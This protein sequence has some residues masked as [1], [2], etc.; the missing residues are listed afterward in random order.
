MDN[1]LKMPETVWNINVIK[2]IVSNFLVSSALYMFYPGT[3]YV[4]VRTGG[5]YAFEE[6]LSGILF[7]IGAIVVAPFCNYCLDTYRRKTVVLW[8]LLC[9]AGCMALFFI[10]MSSASFLVLRTVQ[11][12]ACGVFQIALGS[13]LLLDLSLSKNR[14]RAAHIYYWI[15]RLSLAMGPLMAAVIVKYAEVSHLVAIPLAMSLIAFFLLQSLQVPFRAPLEPSLC[16]LDRFWLS[17]GSR[18]FIPLFGVTFTVGLFLGRNWHFE[19]YV[20]LLVGFLLSLGV[21]SSCFKQRYNEEVLCGLVALFTAFALL[22]LVPFISVWVTGI[23]LGA[24]L[25]LF[26]S[27]YLLAYIRVCEHC[28]RGT[29]Q[30]SYWL[31]WETGLA[32]GG[33]LGVTMYSISSCIVSA[34]ALVIIILVFFIHLFYIRNWYESHKRK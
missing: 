32:L 3:S 30:T 7:V 18:L 15:I 29:A 19:L 34:L 22:Q 12:A 25:G 23:L 6:S 2:I 10:P 14:T 17:R 20:F 28:E 9:M 11:G 13:T 5:D 4:M 26:S 31:G 33:C 1:V 27:R 8:G 21:H 24:G 16:S